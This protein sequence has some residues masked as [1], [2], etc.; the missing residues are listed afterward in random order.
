MFGDLSTATTKTRKIIDGRRA[1]PSRGEISCDSPIGRALIG[2][3]V[4]DIVRVELPRGSIELEIL[5][6]RSPT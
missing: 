4:G 5:K 3:D 1:D 2:R 6:V